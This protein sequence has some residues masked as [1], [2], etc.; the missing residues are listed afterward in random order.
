MVLSGGSPLLSPHIFCSC[1]YLSP[2][3]GGH[4]PLFF[5]VVLLSLIVCIGS[6]GGCF[7]EVEGKETR[8]GRSGHHQQCERERQRE[9][10]RVKKAAAATKRARGE[11][12]TTTQEKEREGKSHRNA[13]EVERRR[14]HQH[15]KGGT[16][17]YPSLLWWVPSPATTW[18]IPSFSL[19]LFCG[20]FPL[21]YSLILWLFLPFFFAKVPFP[22]F[23]C[24]CA[25][26]LLSSLR[27]WLSF[28][29]S[30]F[31]VGAFPPL[32]CCGSPFLSLFCS[33]VLCL[34]CLKEAGTTTRKRGLSSSVVRAL[35][36]VRKVK[37]TQQ[38]SAAVIEASMTQ[39]HCHWQVNHQ[40]HGGLDEKKKKAE[41]F[42]GRQAGSSNPYQV[43]SHW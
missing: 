30:I 43:L 13:R 26:V 42:E 36:L 38:A 11:A 10:E 41:K 40:L 37:V 39:V 27:L 9:R 23:L 6:T 34:S 16:G 19:S 24:G 29:L 15:Q 2:L 7:S 28:P 3:C 31:A 12:A 8:Q 25:G 22:P 1:S 4:V 32:F 33:C 18:W 21:S 20:G 35:V 14:S 17:G 5:S